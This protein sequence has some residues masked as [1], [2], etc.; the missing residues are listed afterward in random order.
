MSDKDRRLPVE[1]SG[2]GA[3]MTNAQFDRHDCPATVR[4]NPGESFKQYSARAKA[5]AQAWREANGV[6]LSAGAAQ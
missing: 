2:C 5:H 6:A 4:P 3:H 1:C